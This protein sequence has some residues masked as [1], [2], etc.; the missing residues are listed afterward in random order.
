MRSLVVRT[1]G[2]EETRAVGLALGRSLSG[3]VT[4]SLEG[5]LGSGKSVLAR[6]VCEAVGVVGTITSPTFT[7]LNEYAGTG[8]RRVIHADCFRLAS[9]EEFRQLGVE[10][11][12]DGDTLLMVEWGDRAL[13]A[14]GEDVIRIE[15]EPGEGNERRIVIRVPDG[16]TLEGIEE[17]VVPERRGRGGECR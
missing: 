16:V 14:L 17:I 1:S 3:R 4:L 2:P 11:R 9:A 5:P 10:D 7:L 8:G 15:L 12:V 13:G 6:G